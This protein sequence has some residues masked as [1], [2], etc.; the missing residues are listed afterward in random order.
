MGSPTIESYKEFQDAY[1]FYNE[2][3]F[4]SELPDCIITYA[5]IKSSYGYHAGQRWKNQDGGYTDELAINPTY[6]PQRTVEQTLSTLVHE[7]CHVWQDHFGTPGRGRYHNKEWAEK[8]KAVGLQPYNT[9]NPDRETGDTV[10]HKIISGGIFE[11]YTKSLIEKKFSFSWVE[12]L[13]TE[14]EAVE[15]TGEPTGKATEGGISGSTK[16]STGGKRVKYSCPNQHYSVWGK[17]G[18]DP[19]CGQCNEYMTSEDESFSAET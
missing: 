4:S 12:R 15:F 14:I 6:V 7:M 2:K 16:K 1:E 9:K 19:V 10:T 11:Q 18:I 5:R 3:L 17:A 8:M 13:E